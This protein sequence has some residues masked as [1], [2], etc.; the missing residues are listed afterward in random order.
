M[1]QVTLI[2]GLAYV[3]ICYQSVEAGEALQASPRV[4]DAREPWLSRE[5][6]G[7]VNIQVSLLLTGSSSKGSSQPLIPI[8]SF[9][10][11]CSAFPLEIKVNF[12]KMCV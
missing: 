11:I 9:I 12:S 3:T 4:Q 1:K 5:S 8:N 10:L 7:I 6:S 2:N